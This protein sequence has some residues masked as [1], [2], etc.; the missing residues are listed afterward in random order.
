MGIKNEREWQ[1]YATETGPVGALYESI[2]IQT[3]VRARHEWD[4]LRLGLAPS[5]FFLV[6][7]FP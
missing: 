6:Q 2:Q 3:I 4:I 7:E 5:I 1:A